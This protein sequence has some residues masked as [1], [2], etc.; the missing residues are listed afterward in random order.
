MSGCGVVNGRTDGRTKGNKDLKCLT[1]PEFDAESH[2]DIRLSSF[3][4]PEAIHAYSGLTLAWI[5]MERRPEATFPLRK[6]RVMPTPMLYALRVMS[7]HHPTCPKLRGMVCGALRDR[8]EALGTGV[9][10]GPERVTFV[11]FT[12]TLHDSGVLITPNLR[13]PQPRDAK[14]LPSSSA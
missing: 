11:S 12:C 9:P 8:G 7:T 6:L 13:H 3:C 14:S 5:S 4:S 2:G 1:D 10:S